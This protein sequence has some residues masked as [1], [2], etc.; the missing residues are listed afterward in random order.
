MEEKTTTEEQVYYEDATV[1]VTQARYIATNK[2]YAMRNVSSVVAFK[3]VRSRKTAIALAIMGILMLISGE[4]L[5]I[6][7]IAL[8]VIG[9]I[10]YFLIKDEYAVRI[11]TNAGEANSIISTDE[12]YIKKIVSALNQAIVNRG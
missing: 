3:I 10:W 9:I 12:T 8:A 6:Y 4:T 11:G 5:R 2:T 7:G 1:T